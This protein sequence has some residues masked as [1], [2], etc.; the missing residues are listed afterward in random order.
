MWK[1]GR[2]ARIL[3]PLFPSPPFQL[4][5]GA[6]PFVSINV[7]ATIFRWVNMTPLGWPVVPEL[8]TKNA[9][10]SFGFIFA[11]LYREAPEIFRTFEKCLNRAVSS[12]SS[13]MRII[14]SSA[15]PAFFAASQA[16]LRNAFCVTNALAPESLSWKASSSGV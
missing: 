9:R 13:P 5:C 7:F 6:S 8:Y 4:K 11:L 12:R 1:N 16:D 10:S 2:K 14:L 15:I 3:S